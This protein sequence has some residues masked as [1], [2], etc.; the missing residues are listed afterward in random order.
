MTT[1]LKA[2]TSAKTI[3]MIQAIVYRYVI[4]SGTNVLDATKSIPV[5]KYMRL[6]IHEAYQIAADPIM[7]V[8]ITSRPFILIIQI[9]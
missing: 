4:L 6:E 9:F 1:S 3:K 2:I 5:M 7:I 8:V